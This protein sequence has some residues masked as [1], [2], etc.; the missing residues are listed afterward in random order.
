MADKKERLA[1]MIEYVSIQKYAPIP[2]LATIF[3]VSDMTIR[4]DLDLLEKAGY[5]KVVKGVAIINAERSAETFSL[6]SYDLVFEVGVNTVEKNKIGKFASSLIKPG[7]SIILDTG[8]TTEQIAKNIPFDMPL[9]VMCNNLNNLLQLKNRPNI[10]LMVAGGLY[11]PNTELFTSDSGVSYIKSF[12]FSKAFISAAG[13]DPK[14]G[15]TCVEEYEVPLKRAM[16]ESSIEHILVID[17]S[18]LGKIETAYFAELDVIDSV[19]IDKEGL[20]AEWQALFESKG[21]NL[22]LA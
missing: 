13:I 12:R 7:D 2:D 19:V 10:E 9:K 1:K 18:K 5:L 14:Y 22:Y 6:P 16:L 3:T 17:S 4:R 15:I 21:I 11:K 8:T 20:T